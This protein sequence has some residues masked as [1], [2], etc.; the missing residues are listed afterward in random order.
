MNKN[1]KLVI[2]KIMRFLLKCFYVFPVKENVILFES[3]EGR[4]YSDNPK[5]LYKYILQTFGNKYKCVWVLNNG[6]KVEGATS[7]VR[8]QSLKYFY[9]LLTSKFI[10]S[11]L[12]IEP[13][14]PKRKKQI[15]LNT[16]HGSG[17][18]KSQTLSEKM[19]NSRYNYELRDYRGKITDYY[20]SGCQK[21]SEV[22][23]ESWNTELSKFI[24][25]GTPRNDVFFSE[26]LD[27]LKTELLQKLNLCADYGYVLFAPTFR[28]SDYRK[29][30]DSGFGLDAQKLLETCEK[31]FNKPFKMLFRAHVG[32]NS[33]TKSDANIIDVSSYPDMQEVMIV[34]DMLITDYSSS[35]WDYSFLKRP[36][37][38]FI[39]DM[40]SYLTER[41]F[42]TSIDSWPFPYA[43]NNNEL[44]DLILNFDEAKN[45]EKIKNH[46]DYLVSF[47]TGN[48]AK[49]I[50]KCLEL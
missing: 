44:Q 40:E 46:L 4:Q 15:F 47:E 31:R 49:Q 11:N 19:G 30:S 3:F 24:P 37:F 9:S 14:F 17:A 8:F 23:A 27:L 42:Y 16:W 6:E 5:Y 28:G 45:L 32:S 34:S 38:L 26:K 10:I 43:K 25:T 50:C 20:V 12:G 39:P 7:T 13:Y 36:G 18:Y 48:A 29:H 41:D 1:I 35:M 22:M 33:S 21:Y 2:I